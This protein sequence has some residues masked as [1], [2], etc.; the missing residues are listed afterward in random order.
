MD[1]MSCLNTIEYV[2][3]WDTWKATLRDAISRARKFGI[4]D[5]VIEDTALKIG[6]FLAQKVCPATK[7]EALLKEMWDVA[8]ESERKAIARL[9]YKMMS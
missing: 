5:A 8:D 1:A 7:E 3:D 6:D 9:M 2:K 4:P